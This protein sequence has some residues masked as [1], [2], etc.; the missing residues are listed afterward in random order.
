MTCATVLALI[1]A[2]PTYLGHITEGHPRTWT[3]TLKITL[4]LWMSLGLVALPVFWLAGPLRLDH[5]D[6][7][8]RFRN[9][10]LHTL[11]AIGFAL[12]HLVLYVRSLVT[13]VSVQRG[14]FSVLSTHIMWLFTVDFLIYWALLGAYHAFYYYRLAAERDNVAL[15]LR[16]SLMES[17]LQALQAQL[18][19]HFFFNTLNAVSVL[20]MKGELSA[21]TSVLAQLSNLLRVSLDDKRPQEVPLATELQFIDGYVQIQRIRFGERLKLVRDVAPGTLNVLVPSLILQPIVENAIVHGISCRAGEGLISIQ[22]ACEN[23]NLQLRVS[24]S[25]PGFGSTI[26]ASR[27]GIGLTNA[28]ERLTCLYGPGDWIDYGNADHGGAVVTV[29]IPMK[30]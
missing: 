7:R 22:A 23:G 8:T 21:V 1:D 29:S 25:G 10:G 2:G 3:E 4:A 18:N 12:T 28:Q 17:R 14:F 15:Q 27:K 26:D 9:V 6:R 19:P 24:D 13:L 20:A 11:A 30:R 5:V 16:A